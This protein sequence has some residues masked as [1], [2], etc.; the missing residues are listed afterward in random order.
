[1]ECAMQ[2]YWEQDVDLVAAAS[3]C[4]VPDCSALVIEYRPGGGIRSPQDWEF[5]CSRCGISFTVAEGNL[6]FRAVPMQWLL[7]SPN[8]A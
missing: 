5:T 3:S 6:I 1:M 8:L 2:P 7:A 4:P